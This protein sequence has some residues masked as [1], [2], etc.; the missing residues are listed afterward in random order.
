MR[1]GIDCLLAGSCVWSAAVLKECY[2]PLDTSVHRVEP[3]LVTAVRT[4]NDEEEK[5]NGTGYSEVV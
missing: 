4:I 5:F 2:S 1:W 3:G